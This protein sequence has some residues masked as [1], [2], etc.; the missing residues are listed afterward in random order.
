MMRKCL[1]HAVLVICILS[2]PVAAAAMMV[3]VPLE[4]I[5]ARADLIVVAETVNAG[6]PTEM[7]M[8]P[9]GYP[10]PVK[11]WFCTYE[12]KVTR[13]IREGGRMVEEAPAK[14]RTIKVL[15]RTA[16]PTP[17]PAPGEV[18]PVMA[19]GPQYASLRV[20]QSYV[21]VLEAIEGKSEYWLPAYFKNFRPAQPEEIAPIVRAADVDK[22]AWGP[23][24]NGLEIA[25]VP[26]HTEFKVQLQPARKGAPPQPK[27]YI[28]ATVALRNASDQPITVNLYPEDRFLSMTAFGPDGQTMSPDWYKQLAVMDMPA[29]GPRFLQTIPP[30][31]ILFV[32]PMGPGEYGLGVTLPLTAG[33][34]K[35]QA[36]YRSTRQAKDDPDQPLWTGT[37]QSDPVEIQVAP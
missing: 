22:W 30:K 2:L 33:G 4:I 18:R 36:A 5:A 35:L 20:G 34:W 12:L 14:Q 15:T 19:D 23:G 10:R 1:K 21:L 6:P 27:A 7:E 24:V 11:A 26:V 17:L 9:P 25:L 8:Q 16:A 29:F 3:D 31:G 32:E 28:Q 13:V 37:I